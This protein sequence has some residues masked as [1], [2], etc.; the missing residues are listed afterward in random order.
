MRGPRGTAIPKMLMVGEGGK[1]SIGKPPAMI[2][3]NTSTNGIILVHSDFKKDE[4]LRP[5]APYVDM[6]VQVRGIF[7]INVSGMFKKFN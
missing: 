4:R 3:S 1:T 6:T 2:W 5:A 7:F